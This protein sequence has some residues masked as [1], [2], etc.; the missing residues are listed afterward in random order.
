[1][2]FSNSS[3]AE[4]HH[5]DHRWDEKARA[6]AAFIVRA[7][8][9]HDDLVKALRGVLTA[10]TMNFAPAD[11]AEELAPWLRAAWD[12]LAKAEAAP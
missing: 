9:A 8:N 1:V 10:P 3:V 6:N 11:S 7:C 2:E 5:E 4:I 12:A